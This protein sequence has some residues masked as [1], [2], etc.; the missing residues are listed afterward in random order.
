MNLCEGCGWRVK[1]CQCQW[2]EVSEFAPP[3]LPMRMQLQLNFEQEESNHA[4]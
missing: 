4:A 1:D 3:K 2:I